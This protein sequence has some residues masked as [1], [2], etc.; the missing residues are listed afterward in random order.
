M[1]GMLLD[2]EKIASLDFGIFIQYLIKKNN[3]D[4]TLER[5]LDVSNLNVK[6]IYR[7]YGFV[8]GKQL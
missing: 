3:D 1:S 6:V 4:V 8:A 5:T 2:K 7:R